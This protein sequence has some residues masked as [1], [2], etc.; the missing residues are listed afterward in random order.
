[1]SIKTGLSGCGHGRPADLDI[2][3]GYICGA[4]QTNCSSDDSVIVRPRCGC[5]KDHVGEA[6]VFGLDQLKAGD[7]AN[8]ADV[9]AP[10]CCSLD[11]WAQEQH[12]LGGVKVGNGCDKACVTRFASDVGILEG[13]DK[14]VC[15]SPT[16]ERV[17]QSI[18]VTADI[19]VVFDCIVARTCIDVCAAQ[20]FDIAV[21]RAVADCVIAFAA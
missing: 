11:V 21:K 19:N 5:F 14:A 3:F 20:L 2:C 6:A 8:R 17:D 16:H 1:M 15:A 9:V 18:C 7:L 4:K 13:H 12:V 10:V